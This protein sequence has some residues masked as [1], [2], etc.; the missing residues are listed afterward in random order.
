[1]TY[2]GDLVFLKASEDAQYLSCVFDGVR[3]GTKGLEFI[4]VRETEDSVIHRLTIKPK[5][6][7]QNKII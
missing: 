1:M 7:V 4:Y 6:K 2:V 5:T 3:E